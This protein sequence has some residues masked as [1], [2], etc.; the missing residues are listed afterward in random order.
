M[1]RLSG[2]I[3]RLIIIMLLSG[4][5]CFGTRLTVLALLLQT[6]VF[7]PFLHV[8]LEWAVLDFD[9]GPYKFNTY[10]FRC[11]VSVSAL[12]HRDQTDHPIVRVGPMLV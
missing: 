12:G 9:L 5:I 10:L 8:M 2:D 3:Y 11:N 4:L 1:T 7:M 6:Q